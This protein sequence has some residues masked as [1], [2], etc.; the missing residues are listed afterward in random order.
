[1]G[2]VLRF[3]TRRYAARKGWYACRVAFSLALLAFLGLFHYAF[4]FG[5]RNGVSPDMA[6]QF[7]AER[8]TSL[9]V[10][11]HLIIAFLV[12]PI[13]AADAFS[14]ERVRTMLPSLLVTELSSRR[15][16]WETFAARLIPG[17]S[18][19]L[20]LVPITVFLVPWWGLDP[21]FIAIMEG[22][23]FG[24]ILLSAAITAAFS[25][26]S[27]RTFH[28]LV[29]AFGL[30]GAWLLWRQVLFIPGPVRSWIARANPY[31]LLAGRWNGTGPPTMAD[32]GFFV[33]VA[34]LVTIALLALMSA[35][36]RRVVLAS[37][38]SMPGGRTRF[39][40][41]RAALVLWPAW[42]PGPT[43]DGNPV[44]WREWRRARASV[45]WRAFWIL[46][47]G[48]ALAATVLGALAFWGGQYA[49]D[50]IGVAG[51]EV[52]IGLLAVAARAASAW[53][54]EKVAGRE[55]LDLLLSTPMSASTI[56]MGKWW[57]AYRG[58]LLVA[59]LPTLAALILAAGAPAVPPGGFVP[60]DYPAP[61][62]W[63]DRLAVPVMVVGQVLLCGAAFVSLGLFLATK[64][65]RGTRA[66][67]VT[68][69]VYIAVALIAPTV[70]EIVF[71]RSDR[72]LSVGLG[73]VSPLAG[74]IAI[75]MSLFFQAYFI[76]TRHILP[77]ALFWLG[78]VGGLA[79]VLARRTIQR[80]DVWMGRMP[81]PPE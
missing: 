2:P 32:A 80:F 10:V 31:G 51:Y 37:P 40:V 67:F 12:A 53:S 55:G 45:G 9:L 47:A 75:L 61:L 41:L 8:L 81:S 50:L 25:L 43:L 5:V 71:L 58:V 24:S 27:G 22:V 76:P 1:M 30:L 42:L 18:V 19:W 21:T 29:G 77:F 63:I 79:S 3:E 46:Y 78:L 54:E 15:I 39:A 36:L 4:W 34:A 7:V 69:A 68:V 49:P 16:V 56:V 62:S 6:K 52:G 60:A 35:A 48:G 64:L 65:A 33:G 70:S 66:V 59:L 11:T 14:R 23:T 28:T 38:R 20:C 13:A 73:S 72:P 17:L 57:G 44:L 74:P 26:W